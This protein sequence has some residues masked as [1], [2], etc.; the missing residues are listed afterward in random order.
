MAD[1][2]IK[3]LFP[4]LTADNKIYVEGEIELNPGP[5]LIEL[6]K[7]KE[8]RRHRDSNRTIKLSKFIKR[9]ELEEDF[10][11]EEFDDENLVKRVPMAVIEEVPED[12][13][14]EKK[15]PELI[16]LAADLG[17]KKPFARTLKKPDLVKLV[18]LLRTF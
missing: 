12:G 4:G 7:S 16:N 18:R 6:T 13:L 14:D 8:V 11:P 15:R 5:D 9:P 17:A 2:A 10:I 1:Y 3:V